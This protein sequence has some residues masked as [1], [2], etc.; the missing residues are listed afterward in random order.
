VAN[1]PIRPS[2]LPLAEHCG[3]AVK[4]S[5]EHA[6]GSSAAEA[7]TKFHSA[8]AEYITTRKGDPRLA[9]IFATM[10]KHAKAEPELPVS[11]VDPETGETLSEGTTDLLLTHDDLSLTNVDFK[12]GNPDK[13]D[14]PDDNLQ[15]LT[16][17]LAAAMARN[18]PRFRVGLYFT[19]YPPLRLSRWFSDGADYWAILDRVRAAVGRDRNQAVRGP[20]CDKCYR[21]TH[22]EAWM[23]P[24]ALGETALAPYTRPAG[25]TK[26]NAPE[27]LRVVKA[28]EDA[29]EIAKAHLKDFA[30]ENDGIIDGNKKWAPVMVNGRRSVS[31]ERLEEAGLLP[32]IEEKGLVRGGGKIEQFRWVNANG[33]AGKENGAV[34]DWLGGKNN[35]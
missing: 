29:L 4:L 16:Y 22:C 25:L 27:A 20:H 21:R 11:L 34:S 1:K 15:I 2:L 18:A 12:T 5:E 35:G 24:A 19:E 13:V 32:L 26:Q 28:M 9:S 30:R 31:I 6:E 3:Y 10:P 17:G 8:M 23:M 33:K 7:G 14:P